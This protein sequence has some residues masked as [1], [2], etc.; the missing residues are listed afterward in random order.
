MSEALSPSEY[1]TADDLK[2]LLHEAE[3]ALSNTADKAGGKFDELRTRLRT[4][5]HNSKD[6]IERLRAEAARHARQADQLV[7]ANPYTAIGIA[8]GVGTLVG[9]LISRSCN[10][11]R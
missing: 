3:L 10:G 1:H 6:S 4:A 2:A 7:R 8:A 5:L 11:S 9:I